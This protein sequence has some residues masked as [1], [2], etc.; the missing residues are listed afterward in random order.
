MI[1]DVWTFAFW[2]AIAAS[3]GGCLGLAR[4]VAA[5]AAA[6]AMCMTILVLTPVTFGWASDES[7]Y[8]AA[9]SAVGMV[10]FLFAALVRMT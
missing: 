2:V 4:R 10:M 5:E 3:T 9:S 7:F 1:I 8:I 6:L